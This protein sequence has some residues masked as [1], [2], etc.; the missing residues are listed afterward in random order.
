MTI[1]KERIV[2]EWTSI[3]KNRRPTEAH[4][5][6]LN[7]PSSSRKSKREKKS[8]ASHLNDDI[9]GGNCENIQNTN[10]SFL[11]YEHAD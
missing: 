6:N 4:Y 3:T 1:M 7:T 11:L 5:I 10:V 2:T 9:D 8:E